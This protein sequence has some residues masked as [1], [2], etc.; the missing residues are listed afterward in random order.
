MLKVPLLKDTIYSIECKILTTTEIGKT[1]TYFGEI[2][3]I[4]M[5]EDL[6]EMEFFDL[7]RINPVIYSPDKHYY[8]IGEYIEEIGDYSK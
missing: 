2:H 1:I 4:N 5:T 7:T 6:G 3:H 8:T